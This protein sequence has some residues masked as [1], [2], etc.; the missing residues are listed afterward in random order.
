MW[1]QVPVCVLA[2]FRLLVLSVVSF[3]KTKVKP[4]WEKGSQDLHVV[5]EGSSLPT[6]L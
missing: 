5:Q 1:V 2:R 6:G 4:Y 3:T